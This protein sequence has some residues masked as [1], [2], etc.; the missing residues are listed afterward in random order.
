MFFPVAFIAQPHVRC[1][2]RMSFFDYIAIFSRLFVPRYTRH[3]RIRQIKLEL[4]DDRVCVFLLFFFS[5]FTRITFLSVLPFRGHR[6]GTL[7]QR[8]RRCSRADSPYYLFSYDYHWRGGGVQK[9]ISVYDNT[10]TRARAIVRYG[11]RK[12]ARVFRVSYARIFFI[13]YVIVVIWRQNRRVRVAEA[14]ASP[15]PATEDER[16]CF[17]RRFKTISCTG[18]F[19]TAGVKAGRLVSSR[20]RN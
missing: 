18:F 20:T 19:L 5:L 12:Y 16:Y 17:H 7:R 13:F 10:C 1:E 15:P 8:R 4:R 3:G 2:S 6:D 9:N 11:R 14:V